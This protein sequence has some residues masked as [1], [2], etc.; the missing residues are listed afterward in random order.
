MNLNEYFD[1]IY[2]VSLPERSDRRKNFI[3]KSY[4]NINFPCINFYKAISGKTLANKNYE[5]A[6]IYGVG[7]LGCLLSH[8]NILV[9][10]SKNNF[11]RIL[12]FEDDVEIKNNFLACLEE[13]L[14]IVGEDWDI[15]Y[16]GGNLED[17]NGSHV[18]EIN[19]K[20]ILRI[21]RSLRTH[22][23]A[24]NSRIFQKIIDFSE[25]LHL[26][27]DEVYAAHQKDLKVYKNL[28]DS[29][30]LAGG[31]SDICEIYVTRSFKD[32]IFSIPSR[33]NNLKIKIKRKFLH[34]D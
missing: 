21:T 23:Y 31:Y 33:L 4:K 24:I 22:A 9:E 26:P 19:G 28:T 20:Q 32:T 3:K 10:A 13:T 5:V 18:V 17:E 1:Q 29:C 30:G 14:N 15:L 6:E 7:Q 2:L 27:I 8:R 16:F 12:I 34:T 25:K 11:K